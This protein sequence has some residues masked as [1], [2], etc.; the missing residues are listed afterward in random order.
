MKRKKKEEKGN[1]VKKINQSINVA[2]VFSF[3]ETRKRFALKMA[4]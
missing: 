3:L 4:V 2:Q 1:T